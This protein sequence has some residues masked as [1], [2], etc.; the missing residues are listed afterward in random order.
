MTI[1]NVSALVFT[2]EEKILADDPSFVFRT[3]ADEELCSLLGEIPKRWGRMP[4]LSRLLLVEAGSLLVRS[5][6]LKAGEKCSEKGRCLGL[7]GGTR[8]GCLYTDRQFIASMQRGEGLASPALFGYTL[9]N[10]PLAEVAVQFGLT[11]PVYAVFDQEAPRTRA[12]EEAKRLLDFH[13]ELYG[14]LAGEFLEEDG[15]QLQVNLTIVA[16]DVED[17][18]GLSKME[19]DS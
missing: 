16:R 11:G 7:V 2:Y 9:P 14:M 12:V 13:P 5:G 4:A 10:S 6:I 8:W 19:Q 17:Y 1:V 3:Y 18:A 15:E